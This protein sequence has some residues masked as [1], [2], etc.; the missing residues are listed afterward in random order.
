MTEPEQTDR[1][2]LEHLKERLEHPEFMPSPAAT[3]EQSLALYLENTSDIPISDA[4]RL[5]AFAEFA[6]SKLSWKQI[7]DVFEFI[8]KNDSADESIGTYAVWISKAEDLI[9]QP[10]RAEEER[11]EI[12][13][14]LISIFERALTITPQSPGLALGLGAS[15]SKLAARRGED[16]DYVSNAVT[17]LNKAV[18]WLPQ[19]EMQDHVERYM[20]ANANLR[21]GQCFIMLRV[22]KLAREHLM[23]AS[24]G[25]LLSGKEVS[26]LMAGI[27]RCDAALGES[28]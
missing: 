10:T 20:Q 25:N 22:Y 21:L 7:C 5:I 15:Y 9:S 13:Q 17:W 23:A 3:D 19:P 6:S 27:A 16:I 4:N 28:N 1:T 11:I 24:R 14:A 18:E 12:A 2:I 8:L 26:E